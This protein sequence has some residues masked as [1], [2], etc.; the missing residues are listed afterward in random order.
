MSSAAKR[1]HTPPAFRCPRSCPHNQMYTRH[2]SILRCSRVSSMTTTLAKSWIGMRQLLESEL[3]SHR[4]R[5]LECSNGNARPRNHP[6]RKS[7]V[8]RCST[9]PRETRYGQELWHDSTLM[10]C[11][12]RA[13]RRHATH[14]GTEVGDQQSDVEGSCTSACVARCV[15]CVLP[16]PARERRVGEASERSQIE[17]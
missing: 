13:P 2:G 12:T 11:F 8:R 3:S 4:C 16:C 1:A 14:M 15:S 17:R 9:K 6:L 7:S 5:S 10:E